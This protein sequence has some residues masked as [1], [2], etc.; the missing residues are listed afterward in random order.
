MTESQ[1]S[2]QHPRS[3]AAVWET[4]RLRDAFSGY[5]LCSGTSL[6]TERKAMMAIAVAIGTRAF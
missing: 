2:W 5:L 4:G 6:L 1:L 3:E